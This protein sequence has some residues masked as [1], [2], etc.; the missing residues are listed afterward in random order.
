MN[1]INDI[2]ST[3]DT[4]LGEN[5]LFQIYYHGAWYDSLTDELL[6][7][8]FPY[9]EKGK[10]NPSTIVVKRINGKT[11]TWTKM[12]EGTPETTDGLRKMGVKPAETTA[13]ELD[14]IVYTI[15][16]EEEQEVTTFYK[17]TA[18]SNDYT[19]LTGSAVIKPEDVIEVTV[20]PNSTLK[21]SHPYALVTVDGDEYTLGYLTNPIILNMNRDH[22]ISINWKPGELVETFRIIATR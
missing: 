5:I 16:T 18:I 22:R 9:T 2:L 17:C 11:Y 4:K 3:P 12:T 10:A 14:E 15:T 8:A 7:Y 21:T 6:A 13:G 20:T 19:T 1:E